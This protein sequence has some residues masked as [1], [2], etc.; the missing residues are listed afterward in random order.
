M[1]QSEVPQDERI[2]EARQKVEDG[3]ASPILYFMELKRM[4]WEIL[5][6]YVGIWKILVKRH[7][8][9]AVFSKLKESTLKKYAEAF[10]ISVEELKNFNGNLN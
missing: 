2:E 4:D 5:S 10:E 9:P 7:I 3:K 8:K 6:N 1:K